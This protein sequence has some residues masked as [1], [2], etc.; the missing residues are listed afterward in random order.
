MSFPERHIFVCTNQ[1]PPGHRRG[2][3]ADKGGEALRD[4][5]K[6]ELAARGLGARMRANAAGCLDQCATGCTVVVYPDQVWYGHVTV[7]DVAEIV[8]RHLIGG[9]PVERLLLP[10]QPHPAR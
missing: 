5:S 3:C 7:D 8:E 2:C 4:R 9:Q 6:Q 10:G 1:R